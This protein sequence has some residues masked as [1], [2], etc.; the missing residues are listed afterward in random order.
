MVMLGGEEETEEEEEEEEDEVL[1]MEG[2]ADTEGMI[3]VGALTMF[4]SN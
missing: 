3:I 2:D 1:G 4:H